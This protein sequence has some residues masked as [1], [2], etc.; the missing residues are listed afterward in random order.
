MARYAEGSIAGE[1]ILGP[2]G[3]ASRIETVDAEG[4]KGSF[5][6]TS[7][8]ALDNTV[9]TQLTQRGVKGVRWGVRVAF[10]L[11]SNL[12]AI[13]AA[14]ETA[15]S[16]GDDFAVEMADAGGALSKA[17]SINVRCVPDFAALGGRP[18]TRGALSG[19]YVK[20]IV[21]RFVTTGEN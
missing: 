7:Q 8:V 14:M 1:D 12:N 6:G 15:L 13:V 21:F 10:M 4:L 5:T 2:G 9:H 16:E 18:Y 11:I 19:D 17:D 20:D 3:A